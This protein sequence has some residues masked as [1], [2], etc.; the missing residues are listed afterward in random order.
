MNFITCIYHYNCLFFYS[1]NPHRKRYRMLLS[2]KFRE[3]DVQKKKPKYLKKN[4]PSQII[5]FRNGGV[6]VHKVECID[7]SV[8]TETKQRGKTF[9]TSQHQCRSLCRTNSV[10]SSLQ[11]SHQI[12]V[13][14]NLSPVS[15]T[16]RKSQSHQTRNL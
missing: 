9:D 3:I 14:G 13:P 1:S 12:P 16:F 5:S 10:I 4:V 7:R 8:T 6:S 15:F 11:G 2:D